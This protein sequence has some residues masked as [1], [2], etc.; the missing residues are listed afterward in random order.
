MHITWRKEW[1]QPYESTWSIIEKIKYANQVNIRD[2]LHS[3]GNEAARKIK[4]GIIA[5]HFL[6]PFF[7]EAFNKDKMY[8]S[9]QFC[10]KTHVHIVINQLTGMM[11]DY[12]SRSFFFRKNLWFC[13]TC[14]KQGY[15]SFLHQFILINECPFHLQ[16]LEN[17]C[18]NCKKA[19][20]FLLS[21]NKHDGGFICKCSNSLII[22]DNQV[23]YFDKWDREPIIKSPDVQN[24]L[25]NENNKKI[26]NAYFYKENLIHNKNS[27][28]LILE[29]LNENDEP[30]GAVKHIYG[31][32]KKI[33]NKK[34]LNDPQLNCFDL[35]QEKYHVFHD[36]I[37]ENVR[38]LL[39][40]I[41]HKLLNGVLK[42]HANCIHK[43]THFIKKEG[44]EFSEVCCH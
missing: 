26:Q 3:W 41:D 24:W 11:P 17:H 34:E 19:I 22:I 25:I 37:Y 36:N 39:K 29:L 30:L 9:L 15:H 13:S 7:L 18:P 4:S 1:I 20:P 27:M 21:S 5:K 38:Q 6:D 40:S 35:N 23:S 8:N 32:K 14:L 28:K 10:I 12:I 31:N 2:L 42:K 43:L 44:E 16:A 33:M